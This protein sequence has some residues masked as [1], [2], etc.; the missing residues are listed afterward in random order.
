M[1]TTFG[2]G[3]VIPGTG[4]V[5]NNEM[6]D[7]SAQPGA[8]NV[9]GLIGAEANAIAPGKRPLSSMSPTIVL[10]DGKPIFTVGAAGGPT[11]ITQV[12]LAIIQVVDFG[13]SPTEALGRARFHHQWKP[14]RLLVEKTLGQAIIDALLAKGH[15]V[16]IVNTLG[17]AQSIGLGQDGKAFRGSPDP[18][19]RGAFTV[20][21]NE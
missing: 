5:M 6:D 19:G 13:K 16:E 4:I 11:I 18:R 20:R 9:F 8:P 14:D 3:V 15:T 1:N 12:V 21:H 10:R 17:A 2:S 7:F